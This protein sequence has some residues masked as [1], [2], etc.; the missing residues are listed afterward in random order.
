MR[1]EV[2]D[3]SLVRSGFPEL[4]RTYEALAYVVRSRRGKSQLLSSIRKEERFFLVDC[5]FLP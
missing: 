1:L 2:H 4:I 3:P 5:W